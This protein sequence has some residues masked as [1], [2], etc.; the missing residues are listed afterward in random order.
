MLKVM[1]GGNWTESK[2]IRYFLCIVSWSKGVK[3]LRG[4]LESLADAEH[5]LFGPDDLSPVFPD[6]S[7]PALKMLFARAVAD[8]LLEPI[9]RGVY[10]YPRAPYP[11]GYTLYHVASK[12]RA[13]AFNYISLESALSDAGVISQIPLSWL[14]VMSSG[15]SNVI[16]C[17]RFGTIEF[18]HTSRSPESVAAR[19]V[20]DPRCRL[21]RARAEL[22][23]EDMRRCRR[24]LDLVNPGEI[25]EPI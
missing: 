4:L 9:C 2:L 16:A 19:L 22:A 23:L 14:T 6:L 8:A 3:R 1:V 12:L 21:F 13:E 17:G 10:F 15:R 25:D 5:Y 7:R 24:P 11:R 20:Y 18:I